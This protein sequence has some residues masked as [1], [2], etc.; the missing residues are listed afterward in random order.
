MGS[1]FLSRKF[2]LAALTLLVVSWLLCE[3]LVDQDVWAKV[4][5]GTVGVYIVGNVGQ[6]LLG[7]KSGTI[8]E[9]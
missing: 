9:K 8:T 3:K 5:L 6:K 7:V 2:I 1:K 4:V